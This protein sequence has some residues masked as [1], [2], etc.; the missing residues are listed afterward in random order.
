[1]FSNES[2]DFEEVLET[3][4]KEIGVNLNRDPTQES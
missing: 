3:W 1:M 4:S 2:E